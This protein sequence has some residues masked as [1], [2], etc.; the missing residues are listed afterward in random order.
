LL[1]VQLV[2]TEWYRANSALAEGIFYVLLALVVFSW[3][4]TVV[5]KIQ[6]WR[7]RRKLLRE[8]IQIAKETGNPIIETNDLYK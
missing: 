2:F 5:T 8:R 7:L 3:I 4:W 1:I 6:Q